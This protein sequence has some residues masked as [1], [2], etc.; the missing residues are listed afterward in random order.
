MKLNEILIK[1][2]KL[3]FLILK[4][5]DS[6]Q[7]DQACYNRSYKRNQRFWESIYLTNN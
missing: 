7:F 2:F 3:K 4:F 6:A 5:T 1:T